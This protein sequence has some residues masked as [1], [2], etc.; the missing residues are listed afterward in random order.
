MTKLETAFQEY[1]LRDRRFD[2][3]VRFEQPIYIARH[4][5]QQLAASIMD[6]GRQM[7]L[8]HG[9]QPTTVLVDLPC[10]LFMIDTRN[11]TIVEE[12]ASRLPFAKEVSVRVILPA[13]S[14]THS[15]R[16]KRR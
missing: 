9:H 14:L 4:D 12:I 10:T 11:L 6:A 16:R 7:I 13:C 2:L 15:V 8:K 5:P 1:E 3:H